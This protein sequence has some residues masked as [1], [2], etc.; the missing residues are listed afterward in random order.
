VILAVVEIDVVKTRWRIGNHKIEP[1]RG[2]RCLKLALSA[3]ALMRITPQGDG[4]IRDR[5]PAFP[6]Q[7][8]RQG[9]D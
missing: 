9:T 1:E 2:A 6:A 3:R 8:Q 4:A 5:R 7:A